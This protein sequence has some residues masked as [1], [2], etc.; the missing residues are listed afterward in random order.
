MGG[1][2]VGVDI[3]IVDCFSRVFIVWT[4]SSYSLCITKKIYA[5]DRQ[6]TNKQTAN[7]YRKTIKAFYIFFTLI[8]RHIK[9]NI[10]F[11]VLL[12]YYLHHH[13]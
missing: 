9:V 5:I 11:R 13:I 4:V 1:K 3:K 12:Y 6:Q 7:E 2:E 10:Y 8:L